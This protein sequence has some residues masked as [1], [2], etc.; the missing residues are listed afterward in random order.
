MVL[1]RYLPIVGG[2]EIQAAQLS[3]ALKER[4]HN[5]QIV[6][7]RLTPDLLS[8]EMIND[9]PVR[10]L[11]PIGLS[12]MANALIIGR[13]IAFFIK[14][15]KEYDLIHVHN[16]GP[17]GIAA[18]VA[19]SLLRKPVILKAPGYGGLRRKDTSVIQPSIYSLLL[20]RFILPPALWNTILRRASAII[21]ISQEIL[22]EGLALGFG[23]L[24]AN[25]PNGVDTVKFRPVDSQEAKFALRQR[26]ELPQDKT[27]LLFSGRLAQGKRVDVLLN[28]LPQILKHHPECHVLLAGSGHMQQDSSEDRLRQMAHDLD[29]ADHI[30][31]L[32]KIENIP[33]HL[34][35]AN[36]Y[37]FPSEHEGM[38]N[39]ILEAMATGL[40]IVASRIGGVIDL[41][42]DDSAWLNPV[43]D[44]QAFAQ[45]VCYILDNPDEARRRGE[46]VR[47]LTE[48]TYS[49]QA[50]TEQYET[51][52]YRLLKR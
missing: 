51:L 38:P 18:I 11:S 41:L 42:D 40:P 20:R 26:L 5:I 27:L 43:G 34:Q 32:G 10:R 52:Y 2:A 33:E 25:I 1:N 45:S 9:I 21:A 24:M 50:I 44:H 7:R 17:I 13:L 8:Q 19:G 12:H 23:D 46:F 22:Q 39:A 30:T 29:I 37:V 47:Q 49:I 15:R 28:A 16:I 35:A 48:K 36:I 14:N 3:N 4:G 6:T 31:F